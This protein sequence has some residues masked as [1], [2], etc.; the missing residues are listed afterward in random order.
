MLNLHTAN[1]LA[2][3]NSRM[4]T[5]WWNFTCVNLCQ[6]CVCVTFL[7]SLTLYLVSARVATCKQRTIVKG[8]HRTGVWEFVHSTCYIFATKVFL[9]IPSFLPVK[10]FHITHFTWFLTKFVISITGVIIIWIFF[11]KSL[12]KTWNC[13]CCFGGRR[14][15]CVKTGKSSFS[16]IFIFSMTPFNNL[17]QNRCHNY[18]K[19]L[20]WHSECNDK[21][22]MEN[23]LLI[24][25]NDH[26]HGPVKKMI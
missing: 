5:L 7:Q 11:G 13:I 20:S 17:Y 16:E 21:L 19:F 1:F 22:F 9:T 12:D 23:Y 24:L 8:Q 15:R 10:L 3:L 25:S 6:A 4:S 26:D 18:W 14:E 2:L